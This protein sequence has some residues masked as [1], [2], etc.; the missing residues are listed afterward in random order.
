MASSLIRRLLPGALALGLLA[1][2]GLAATGCGGDEDISKERF[3]EDFS[4]KSGLENDIDACIVDELFAQLDQ[5]EINDFYG[6][7]TNEP[8]SDENT[9]AVEAAS[10]KCATESIDIPTTTAAE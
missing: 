7:D 9:A 3:L 5:E 10:S 6:A 1:G 8:L 4:E 2:A